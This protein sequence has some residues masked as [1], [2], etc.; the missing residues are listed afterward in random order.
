L[1]LIFLTT[2][3]ETSWKNSWVSDAPVQLA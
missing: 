1:L 3:T 2:V